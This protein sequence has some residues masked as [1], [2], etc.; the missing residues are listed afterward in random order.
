MKTLP[1][2]IAAMAVL[3]LAGCGQGDLT[4]K[5]Q[6]NLHDVMTK[7]LVPPHRGAGQGKAHPEGGAPAP[8]A[9]SP[10]G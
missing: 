2:A 9:P 8:A 3:V 4:P 6:E 10:G 7:G 5:Q 1:F